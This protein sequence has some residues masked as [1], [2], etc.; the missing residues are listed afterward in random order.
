[1]QL[2]AYGTVYDKNVGQRIQFSA[3]YDLWQYSQRLPRTR[4]LTTGKG[5]NL[6]NMRDNW[7]MVQDTT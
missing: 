5:N 3:I 2:D 7:K 6:S 4:A 1:L